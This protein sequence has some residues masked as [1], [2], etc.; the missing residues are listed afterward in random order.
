MQILLGV[1]NIQERVD[2]IER[3]LFAGTIRKSSKQLEK[4]KL[5]KGG[6]G[7]HPKLEPEPE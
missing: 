2:K 6:G 3:Q 1:L 5:K 4:N 7:F